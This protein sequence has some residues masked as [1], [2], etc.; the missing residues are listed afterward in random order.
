MM[1]S[2][3]GKKYESVLD[4]SGKAFQN[5]A[6]E[7]SSIGRRGTA[8]IAFIAGVAFTAVS[9]QSTSSTMHQ[10]VTGYD[11]RDVPKV[12]SN[13]EYRPILEPFGTENLE[14]L[15]EVKFDTF[16]ESAIKLIGDDKYKEM[17]IQENVGTYGVTFVPNTTDISGPSDADACVNF[18]VTLFKVVR[19]KGCIGIEKLSAVFRAEVYIAG[20]FVFG[21]SYSYGADTSLPLGPE[22]SVPHVGHVYVNLEVNAFD[23]PRYVQVCDVLEVRFL[24]P[25]RACS[26]KFTF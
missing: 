8:I 7:T 1:T 19:T 4:S 12:E 13:R 26:A 11:A 9:T 20:V 18:D 6:K 24:R 14:P 22:L 2:T 25:K 5:Q 23:T 16:V 21:S 3:Y 15:D 17:V 10:S